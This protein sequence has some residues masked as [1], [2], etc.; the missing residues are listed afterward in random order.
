MKRAIV[1]LLLFST[2]TG[3][4]KHGDSDVLYT[5]DNQRYFGEV[6]RRDKGNNQVSRTS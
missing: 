4:P 1:T 5:K 6:E 2:I 3:L